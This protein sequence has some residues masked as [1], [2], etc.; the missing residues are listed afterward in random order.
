MVKKINNIQ[1][2]FLIIGLII[3]TADIFLPSVV[4]KHA[5]ADSWFAV[6]V[7]TIFGLLST[8]IVVTLCL[9]HKNKTIIEILDDTLGK[10][11]GKII[12]IIFFILFIFANA[13]IIREL[14][15]ILNALFLPGMPM[16]VLI[17]FT[18]IVTTYSVYKGIEVIARTNEVLLPL[19]LFVLSFVIL[20]SIPYIEFNRFMPLME[21]GFGPSIRGALPMFTWMSEVI[22]IS[23][24][25]PYLSNPKNSMKYSMFAVLALGIMFLGGTFTILVFSPEVTSKLIYAPFK[26]VE[27]IAIERTLRFDFFI[28]LIWTG[29]IFIKASIFHFA[30]V[31]SISRIINSK[32]FK[33]FIVPIGIINSV[34]ALIEYENVV[35]LFEYFSNIIYILFTL[36]FFFIPLIL[37]L[38]TKIKKVKI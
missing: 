30:S 28:M 29:G 33:E 16:I 25:F 32:N 12:S 26:L 9:E 24:I 27:S 10:Y 14:A 17:I 20:F 22:I 23:M 4:A 34:F 3:S 8:Y 38:I 6:I 31:E 1:L 21:N 5:K 19:G 2:L 15:E 35:E 11:I 36:I 18:S 37:L 7:A 13:T